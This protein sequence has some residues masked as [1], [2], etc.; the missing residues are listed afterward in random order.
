[1]KKMSK[2]PL[3]IFLLI[4][5]LYSN[6]QERLI[7]A[8][9]PIEWLKTNINNPKVVIVDLRPYDEYKKGHL[10]NAVNIPG[11]KSLFDENFFMPKLDILKKI[12]SDAGIDSEKLV[13]A[14]DNGDF[15]WAA[16]FY[17]ILQTLGHENVGILKVAYG[18][19]LMNNFEIS[20]Q[21]TVALKSEF[22]PR[23]DNSKIETK[24]STLL[25][26]GNK[27][28]IDGR[29]EEHYDGK[30]SIAKRFGHIPTAKNYACTQNFQVNTTGN[31]MR[32]LSELKEIYKDIPKDKKVLLYCDGGADAAL[33][34]IVLQELGYKAA[35]YDGSWAEWGNDDSVPIE[36]PSKK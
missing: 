27:T 22:I 3:V 1:M 7:P 5:Y 13:V 9:T 10:K 19:E 26:I 20:T 14:Y 23:I 36:N 4:S 8:I 35:V 18:K 30:K 15:I 32:E 34:Y 25:S 28:I 33:N 6:S 11:L 17:W 24:L 21:D 12:F 16:R 31:K 2:I 29:Q